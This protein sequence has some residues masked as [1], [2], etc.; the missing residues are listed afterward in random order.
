M[1]ADYPGWKPRNYL[2]APASW[3]VETSPACCCWIVQVTAQVWARAI[4]RVNPAHEAASKKQTEP[5]ALEAEYC[6]ARKANAACWAALPFFV[7]AR[8]DM[9]LIE[10]TGMLQCCWWVDYTPERI[11]MSTEV[12][13]RH[14]RK[15]LGYRRLRLTIV[16]VRGVSFLHWRRFRPG[17]LGLTPRLLVSLPHFIGVL[18]ND[19]TARGRSHMRV[20]RRGSCHVAVIMV[21]MGQ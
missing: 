17:G 14:R 9:G 7:H 5:Q 13:M 20:Q 1:W 4:A 3:A 18:V 8:G 2:R 11:L 21:L 12:T 6:G 10:S 19:D 15:D 16:Q